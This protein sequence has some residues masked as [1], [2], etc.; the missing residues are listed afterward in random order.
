[1]AIKG[2][3]I[4]VNWNNM[5]ILRTDIICVF[6]KLPPPAGDGRSG[7]S[8]SAD[9]SRLQYSIHFIHQNGPISHFSRP[10]WALFYETR[11]WQEQIVISY[12]V[13]S[14]ISYVDATNGIFFSNS[15]KTAIVICTLAV[16]GQEAV[17]PVDPERNGYIQLHSHSRFRYGKA[18][19]HSHIETIGRRKN[20]Q[21]HRIWLFLG[22]KNAI[23]DRKTFI[24][25]KYILNNQ[26][27]I[28]VR[29]W[30]E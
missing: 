14:G 18:R 6:L 24:N 28:V 27:F 9:C 16:S 20:R 2:R 21:R 7:G 11:L 30:I 23:L 5:H 3:A 25:W 12:Q 19:G 17:W 22:L 8:I 1:M 29:P 15:T 10:K 26:Y 4:A 13:T